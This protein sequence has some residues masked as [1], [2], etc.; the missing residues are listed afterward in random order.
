M[1]AETE[2][3]KMLSVIISVIT[4]LVASTVPVVTGSCFILTTELA[5]VTFQNSKTATFST[6]YLIRTTSFLLY[7]SITNIMGQYQMGALSLFSLKLKFDPFLVLLGAKRWQSLN[8]VY[9]WLDEENPLS[10][11]ILLKMLVN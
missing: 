6:V 7:C 2:M 9:M 3:M 11:L 1:N 8:I 10:L 4:T 5:K